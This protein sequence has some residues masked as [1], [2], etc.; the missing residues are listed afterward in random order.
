MTRRFVIAVATLVLLALAIPAGAIT[1]GEPD[2]GEHP[3]VGQLLFYVPDEADSRFDDPGSWYNCTGTLISPTVV[4][5]AGHCVFGVGQDGEAT[6]GNAG[7]VFGNDIWITFEEEADY[8][9]F[10][11][12]SGYARDE[13]QKRYEDRVDWLESSGTWIRA[14]VAK[15]HPAYDNRAFFL[16]DAGV[17]VLDEAITGLGFGELPSE[18]YLNQFLSSPKNEQR[19]TPVGYGLRYIRPTKIEFGD[20]RQQASVMLIGLKGVFGIPEGVAV[21]FSNNNGKAHK[22]GTCFGDSGGPIFDG[23]SN[24]IVAVNSFG[25][26]G[27]CAGTGGGYRI[28]KQPDLGWIG[29]HLGG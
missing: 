15:A 4:L 6:S 16:Y 23:D 27:N 28:D 18:G 24:V 2:D 10:P 20:T 29:G 11:P 9:G 8:D 14:T 7:N 19:F 3:Y 12:S 17:V 21:K 26:N 13:N 1:S 5:T 22:G 25:I